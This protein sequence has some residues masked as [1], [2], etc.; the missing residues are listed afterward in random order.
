M[1]I[2]C[3]LCNRPMSA[4]TTMIGREAFGPQCSRKLGLTKLAAQTGSRVLRF[5]RTPKQADTGRNLDLF[6]DLGAPQDV[7]QP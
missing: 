6:F 2:R 1:R 3:S 5:G 4:P 7:E